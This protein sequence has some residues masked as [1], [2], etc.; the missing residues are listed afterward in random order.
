M[1][2]LSGQD[3]SFLYFETPHSPMHIGSF[4]IYDPS[5]APSGFV[6]F[7]DILAHME[8]R[9]HLSRAFRQ[10]LV[11]VPM[12]MDHP[13]WIMDPEF[14]LEFHVRHIALPSPGDWRQ[15]CI[16]VARLHSRPLD[17]S[18][19]LW[20]MYV[21]E[22]LDNV[23]GCPPGS[24]AVMTKIHHAIIDGASGNEITTFIHDVEPDPKDK[25]TVQ[26]YTPEPEPNPLELMARA[27]FNNATQPYRFM[28]VMTRSM[29]GMMRVTQGL[30][31][32]EFKTA[33]QAPRTRF[34]GQV[35]SHRVIDGRSFALDDVKLIK[36]AV[37]GA[38]IN[39][40]VLAL[41]GGALRHYLEGKDE[42]PDATL[43]AMA[44]ISVRA[45]GEKGTAGNQ[46]S[47]MVVELG[48]Q[49]GDPLERLKFVFDS[50]S[51]SKA[52]TKAIGARNLADY[53]KFIPSQLAGLASRLM[54]SP[55]FRAM[56]E[57]TEPPFNTTVTNVPGPDIPLYFAGAE[58]V[59]FV[60]FGPV[61]DNMGLIH[62]IYSYRGQLAVCFTS[63]RE[64][65]PDPEVYSDCIQQS[66]DELKAAAQAVV[67]GNTPQKKA[68]R[69]RAPRK[70]APANNKQD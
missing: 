50:T 38:T 57:Q 42:L 28:E 25:P 39:D 45:E 3:A 46:V 17:L 68:P 12:N 67:G 2:Q 15:L 22:G 26:P 62:P 29:P 6:R 51:N 61:T 21:I 36:S 59:K 18:K 63:C 33:G 48:S 31:Q 40:A 66:F 27:N 70:K 8:S 5:T 54:T 69:K 58:A 32:N 10:K 1:E 49:L 14:D 19:P 56:T 35:T 30:G 53:S 23:E 9:L 47:A 16:Q 4:F 64:M 37:P 34:N 7:K 11:H 65:L 41:V 55:A 60:G 24:F 43:I 52:I 20:E 44:P 13:Y